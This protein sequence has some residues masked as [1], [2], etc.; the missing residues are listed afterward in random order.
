MGTQGFRRWPLPTTLAVLLVGLFLTLSLRLRKRLRARQDAGTVQAVNVDRDARTCCCCCCLCSSKACCL[1][2]GC[3]WAM[4][5]CMVS[6]CCC[7]RGL[8]GYVR[9]LSGAGACRG[10]RAL[11]FP[12][13]ERGG[14]G[15]RGSRSCRLARCLRSNACW[16]STRFTGNPA[17]HQASLYR[18]QPSPNQQAAS[19]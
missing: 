18:P 17:S 1:C 13:Q 5:S 4:A 16:G 12:V 15:R 7:P 11:M 3:R 2:S 9:R 19:R 14:G 8:A 10:G 6:S